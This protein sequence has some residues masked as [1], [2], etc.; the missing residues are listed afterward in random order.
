[1]KIKRRPPYYVP[2][3]MYQLTIHYK[4][5]NETETKY[6]KIV[7]NPVQLLSWHLREIGFKPI[8]RLELTAQESG[9]IVLNLEWKLKEAKQAYS[10]L[11]K[12]NIETRDH[13][14]MMARNLTE[15]TLKYIRQHQSKR[16]H[17]KKG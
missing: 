13:D 10:Q 9:L 14:Y 1:M 11:Q 8:T 16:S 17:K 15:T 5:K 3:I 12:E 4:T 6:S 2:K 7:D